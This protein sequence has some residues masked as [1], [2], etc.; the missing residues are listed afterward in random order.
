MPKCLGAKRLGPKRL[1]AETSRGRNGSVPKRLVTSQHDIVWL[2]ISRLGVSSKY[3]TDSIWNESLQEP[4]ELKV[5]T[6]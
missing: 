5:L 3:F 6:V 2:S 1:G 4:D